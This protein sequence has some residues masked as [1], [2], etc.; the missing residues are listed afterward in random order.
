MVPGLA[1]TVVLIVTTIVTAMGIAREKEMGMLLLLGSVHMRR[2]E[3]PQAV[4]RY[5]AVLEMDPTHARAREEIAQHLVQGGDPQGAEALLRK[6]VELA[7]GDASGWRSLGGF[8]LAW[9][10]SVDAF[11]HWAYE[12]PDRAADPANCDAAWGGLWDRFIAR[13]AA[14]E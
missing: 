4:K 7:P 2:E 11:Q 13:A 3:Y 9:I 1:A 14:G 10:A 8:L 5:D 6:Q 12:N